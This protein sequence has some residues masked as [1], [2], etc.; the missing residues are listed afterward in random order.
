[1]NQKNIFLLLMKTQGQTLESISFKELKNP[2]S[3]IDK[4]INKFLIK[5]E[6]VKKMILKIHN[7]LESSF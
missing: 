3:F 2:V 6:K 7:Q 1:M 5:N 4:E